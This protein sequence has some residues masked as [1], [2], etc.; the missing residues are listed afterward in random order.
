MLSLDSI[1]FGG[2]YIGNVCFSIRNLIQALVDIFLT[3]KFNSSIF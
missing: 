3:K 2:N 1:N